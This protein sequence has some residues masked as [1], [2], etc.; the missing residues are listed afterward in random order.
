MTLTLNTESFRQALAASRLTMAELSELSRLDK[1]QLHRWKSGR[2][3]RVRV[4]SLEQVSEALGCMF[5]DLIQDQVPSF[6]GVLSVE[7][8]DAPCEADGLL[9]GQPKT[10]G[11]G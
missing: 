6:G 10:R 1:R 3:T 8:R 11:G 2:H 4:S 7:T 9:Y 5:S